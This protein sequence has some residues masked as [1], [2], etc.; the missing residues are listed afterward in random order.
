MFSLHFVLV[1]RKYHRLSINNV[2]FREYAINLNDNNRGLTISTFPNEVHMDCTFAV[3]IS[4]YERSN[5]PPLQ[6]KSRVD[7][8]VRSLAEA[9]CESEWRP[10][11]A[12]VP[13]HFGRLRWTGVSRWRERRDGPYRSFKWPTTDPLALSGTLGQLAVT[14]CS[15][16]GNTQ[17]R[18]SVRC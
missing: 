10:R 9:V 8:E 11:V 17:S 2:R 5:S 13:F 15:A 6:H 7:H 3:S 12:V 18:R 16:F 4:C 1:N 14:Q